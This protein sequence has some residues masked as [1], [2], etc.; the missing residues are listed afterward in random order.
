MWERWCKK[1]SGPASRLMANES[2]IWERG[3]VRLDD[4]L[5]CL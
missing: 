3:Y 2:V 1:Q 5:I 4:S